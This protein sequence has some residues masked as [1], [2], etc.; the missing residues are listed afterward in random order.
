MHAV[1]E[2]ITEGRGRKEDLDFLEDLAWT[3]SNGS[4]CQLGATAANPGLR[5]ANTTA[6]TA[7]GATAV[8]ASATGR[9]PTPVRRASNTIQRNTVGTR[10]TPV[11]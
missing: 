3:I 9:R 1:L 7:I 6:N 5:Y 10:N 8:R 11:R 4:L 2:D